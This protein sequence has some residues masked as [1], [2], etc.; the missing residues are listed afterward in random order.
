MKI[1]F[2]LIANLILFVCHD[3]DDDGRIFFIQTYI[4]WTWPW[5]ISKKETISSS[6]FFFFSVFWPLWT[7]IPI[8]LTLVIFARNECVF[9]YNKFSCEAMN[10]YVR[11]FSSTQRIFYKEKG[12]I[13]WHWTIGHRFYHDRQIWSDIF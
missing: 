8:S 6:I 5:I 1:S 4:L 10:L 7:I 11:D 13:F 2:S 9:Y 3:D 12:F